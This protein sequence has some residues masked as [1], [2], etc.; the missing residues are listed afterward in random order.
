MV[1]KITWQQ[2]VLSA[3]LMSSAV[4]ANY[5]NINAEITTNVIRAADETNAKY[6]NTVRAVE[7]ATGAVDQAGK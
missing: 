2:A 1:G 6:L 4:S 5:Q 7:Q 3:L